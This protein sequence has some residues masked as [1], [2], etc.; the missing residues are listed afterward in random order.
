MIAESPPLS[1][2][3]GGIGKGKGPTAEEREV[4]G[5]STGDLQDAAV[6]DV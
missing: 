4:E 6:V 2:F 1:G 3:V 5:P